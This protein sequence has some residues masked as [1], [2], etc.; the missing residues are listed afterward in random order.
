MLGAAGWVVE[1]EVHD[2]G[3]RAVVEHGE[4]AAGAAADEAGGDRRLRR[5]VGVGRPG[6]P[7]EAVA[8]RRGLRHGGPDH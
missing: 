5:E 2:E 3:A 8:R 1:L 6:G 4:R 7:A